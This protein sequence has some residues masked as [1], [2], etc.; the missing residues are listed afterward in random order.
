MATPNIAT[1]VT[2]RN[3]PIAFRSNVCW[4]FEAALNAGAGIF[5]PIFDVVHDGRPLTEIEVGGVPVVQ[6]PSPYFRLM[7]AMPTGAGANNPGARLNVFNISD[8]GAQGSPFTYY[9]QARAGTGANVYRYESISRRCQFRLVNTPL[10]PVAA[11]VQ[12]FQFEIV[13]EG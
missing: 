8:T 9:I 3:K 1:G 7:V 5:T 4:R 13:V 6:V 2:E 11:L 10:G 12:T